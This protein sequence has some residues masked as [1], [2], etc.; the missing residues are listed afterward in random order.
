MRP[1][2]HLRLHMP[3]Q[4]AKLLYLDCWCLGA[5]HQ[6]YKQTLADIL[7][8]LYKKGNGISSRQV[9]GRMLQMTHEKLIEEKNWRCLLKAA[10]YSS[11][12][13]H[14]ATGL[15]CSIA[16][17]IYTGQVELAQNDV[18]FVKLPSKNGVRIHSIFLQ[19]PMANTS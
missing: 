11:T 15:P 10:I 19:K 7:Q 17:K 6:K 18:V 4:Y 2:H 13:V 16:T 8:Q 9:A 3:T 12:A 1:K 14:E 5:K